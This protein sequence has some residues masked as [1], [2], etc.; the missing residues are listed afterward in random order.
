MSKSVS[1]RPPTPLV[2]VGF[3]VPIPRRQ[4]Q[5]VLDIKHELTYVPD[6]TYTSLDDHNQTWLQLIQCAPQPIFS[7]TPGGKQHDLIAIV[8]RLV[9][10]SIRCWT[11]IVETKWTQWLSKSTAWWSSI[12]NAHTWSANK[13]RY[14]FYS[15]VTKK[16]IWNPLPPPP[17]LHHKKHQM[18]A[19]K[20]TPQV[21]VSMTTLFQSFSFQIFY[22][23]PYEKPSKS[24]RLG[25]TMG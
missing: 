24:I 19:Q 5:Y 4:I 1:S 25:M 3:F 14:I 6:E 9:E 13:R 16:M 18:I 17:N 11:W 23:G 22:R 7:K 15:K 8:E 2:E 10:T 20:Y 12:R 21:K